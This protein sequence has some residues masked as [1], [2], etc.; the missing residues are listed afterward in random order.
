MVGVDSGTVPVRDRIAEGHDCPG[1]WWC[2]NHNSTQKQSGKDGGVGLNV[3]VT[4]FIARCDIGGLVPIPVHGGRRCHLWQKQAYRQAAERRDRD[5]HWVTDRRCSGR[6]RDGS[7]AT[8]GK[9]PARSRDDRG[10]LIGDGNVRRAN[11]Q[12]PR[13]VLV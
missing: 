1:A 10:T 2:V 7:V 4:D 13:S 8:K 9:C 6:D 3:R 12:R 11:H 5:I